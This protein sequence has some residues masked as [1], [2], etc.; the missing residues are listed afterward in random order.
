MK[1]YQRGHFNEPRLT[2]KMDSSCR[3]QKGNNKVKDGECLTSILDFYYSARIV[4]RSCI[5]VDTPLRV[6]TGCVLIKI[7]DKKI[8]TH[9][10]RRFVDI[11]YNRIFNFLT[12]N[13]VKS[14]NTLED[15]KHFM[16]KGAHEINKKWE[17]LQNRRQ[18]HLHL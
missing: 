15:H 4:S 12:Q 9:W 2:F 14:Y 10:R 5:L 13:L 7:K 17:N 11:V 16:T 8:S 6:Q 1:S 18:L 3:E